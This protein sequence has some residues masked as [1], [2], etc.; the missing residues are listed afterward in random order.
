MRSVERS[1]VRRT[2]SKSAITVLYL[3]ASNDSY[4]ILSGLVWVTRVRFMHVAL[5]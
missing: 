5:S 1:E 4:C 3:L 2:D